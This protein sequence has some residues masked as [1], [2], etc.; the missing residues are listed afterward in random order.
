MASE[1]SS[2]LVTVIM[3]TYQGD[4][5]NHLTEAIDSILNQTYRNFELLIIVDGPLDED[6]ATYLS[7]V[8]ELD[9]VNI[10]RNLINKGPAYSRNVGINAA[11]GSY[12]AIMDA[13]DISSPNRLLHQL[14][15]ITQHELDL[16]SSY[17]VVV[18]EQGTTI[19]IRNV[20]IDHSAVKRLAPFRCP[21]HNPSAFGKSFVFKKLQY[22]P[23]LRVSEDYD[24]WIR[25]LIDGYKLGN[26]NNPCVLY[27]QSHDAVSK[28]IGLKYAIS[29]LKVK[30]RATSI[31][32]YYLIPIVVSSAIV[33]SIARLL[34]VYYFGFIYR[35]RINK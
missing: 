21:L 5:F 8:S 6:R 24:L 15:Y 31:C 4:D 18:D 7:L 11:R 13:D 10:Y 2:P 29:D 34:P 1:M 9:Y 25:A 26:T 17:L 22:N 32:P 3:A 16:I 23:S 30:W 12:I 33:A 19:G 28:R 14:E 20:P 35:F 27:R